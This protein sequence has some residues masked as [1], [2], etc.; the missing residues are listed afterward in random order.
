MG[1][2]QSWYFIGMTPAQAMALAFSKK[3]EPFSDACSESWQDQDIFHMV[4]EIRCA[5]RLSFEAQPN[6]I[7]ELLSLQDQLVWTSEF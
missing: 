2:G 7:A 5:L 3:H 4:L 6:Q 1:L